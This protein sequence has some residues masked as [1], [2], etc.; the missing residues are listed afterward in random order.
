[1][2]EGIMR[3]PSAGSIRLAEVGCAIA[4]MK[5]ER[6]QMKPVLLTLILAGALASAPPRCELVEKGDFVIEAC[7]RHVNAAPCLALLIEKPETAKLPT[8]NGC[9]WSARIYKGH[10]TVPNMPPL[11]VLHVS[12]V[13]SFTDSEYVD[14]T[15]SGKR[16]GRSYQWVRKDVPVKIDPDNNIPR[17]MAEFWLG[18][19]DD[20][21]GVPTVEMTEKGGAR[22]MTHAYK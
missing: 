16:G 3:L 4:D 21:D 12:V 9:A 10:T 7:E 15:L 17:A 1:M 6:H 14:V 18:P 8:W 11:F 19:V 20:L 22:E 5:I 13:P 2:P